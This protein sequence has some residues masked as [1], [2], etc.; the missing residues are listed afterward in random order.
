MI[1]TEMVHDARI[2]RMGG[3]APAGP[4]AA[5][6]GRLDRPLGR[7]HAGHRDHE[8]PPA[9]GL[10]RLVREPQGDRATSPAPAPTAS[11]TASPSRIRRR[12]PRRGRRSW[13][14][15]ASTSR[16]TNTRVTRATTRCPTSSA[17]S[18]R[19]RSGSRRRRR[20]RSSHEGARP[21]HRR[22]TPRVSPGR[23]AGA[24]PH[25]RRVDDAADAGWQARP[26]GLVEQRDLDAARARRGH[27]AGAV[28]GRGGADGA[29]IRRARRAAGGSERPEPAGAA[30]GRRRVHGRGRQRR[31][32]QQ[33]LDRPRRPRRRRQWRAPQ[34]RSSSIRRT[35][36]CRR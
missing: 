8:L 22:C 34:P 10:P 2:I 5:V 4:R 11:S 23:G 6:D 27:A 15:T 24:G 36:A 30:E 20:R 35:A 14:S 7:R 32:L 17:A 1:M 25:R 16:S 9:A 29:G 3:A 33:L 31:R 12:S 18:A 21:R 13:R 28:E 26:P 19:A